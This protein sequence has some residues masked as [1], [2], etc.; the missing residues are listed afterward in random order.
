MTHSPLQYSQKSIE[1]ALEMVHVFFIQ[2]NIYTAVASTSYFMI[3][4]RISDFFLLAKNAHDKII[5]QAVK[6]A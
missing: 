4:Y 1:L 3:L 5:I 2:Y 6:S